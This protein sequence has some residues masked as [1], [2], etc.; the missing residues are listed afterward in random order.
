[1][2]LDPA[3]M[4]LPP[5]APWFVVHCEYTP[6][7]IRQ[8]IRLGQ[9]RGLKQVWIVLVVILSVV[10]VSSCLIPAFTSNPTPGPGGTPPATQHQVS[11]REAL[12]PLLPFPFIFIFLWFAS[13]WGVRRIIAARQLK[14]FG[15]LQRPRILTFTPQSV[16]VREPLASGVYLWPAFLEWKETSD[17]FI[18]YVSDSGGAELV[19]KNAVGDAVM[20]ERFRDMLRNCIVPPVRRLAPGFPVAPVP[21]PPLVTREI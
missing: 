2:N 6:A 17:L 9:R 7:A 8:F 11:L 5:Q 1:M 19:M 15:P 10:F 12:R 18:L 4:P 16:S 14:K 20:L 13:N 21:P 3:S